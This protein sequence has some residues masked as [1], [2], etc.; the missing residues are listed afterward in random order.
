MLW[1][2]TPVAT[3]AWPTLDQQIRLDAVTIDGR[4]IA[5]SLVTTRASGIARALAA[6]PVEQVPQVL[7]QLFPLCS[8]AHA[9]AGLAAIEAAFGIEVSSAQLAFRELMLL[10]EHGAALG[11]R[12][13]MDWPPL[14]N[15]LPQVRAC[16]DIRRAAAAVSTVAERGRWARIGG[17]RLRP[18][19]D[20]LGRTV[21]ELARMLVELFPEAADPTLSWNELEP[22]MQ[23]G[24]S[25]P[26]R[27]INIARGDG[28]AGCGRHDRPLL[29]SMDA[30]WF[31]A[32]LAAEPQ[33]SNAPTLDGTPAE[34]G[35]L[36]AQRHPL[37][38][39]AIAHWGPTLATRLLAAALDAPVVAGRL[40]GAFEQ[41][42]DDDP[43]DVN[44]TRTGH[45]AGMVE[46]ARG[47]L[48]YFVDVAVGRVR[49]LRSVAPTEW[50]FH[51]DGPFM[52]ALAAAPRVPDPLLAARLLAASFDPCVPFS[53]EL[54][55]DQRP[56]SHAEVA[57]HA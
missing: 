27:L 12:I 32:R 18:D 25:T 43:V 51:P 50:N 7:S 52:A 26:A 35:P 11:W 44:L 24:A 45:G 34:V 2:E 14:F 16:A 36:A 23:G 1:E 21:S 41:L 31:A 30:D 53:I 39:D 54:A 8:T 10:A 9:V 3:L 22:A 33:F 46:T 40:C 20:D 15:G 55:G 42:T 56:P 38:T 5:K 48:A 13:L 47:P 57:L 37:V 49:M 28:M 19:R 6:Q 17:M 4:L 29:P